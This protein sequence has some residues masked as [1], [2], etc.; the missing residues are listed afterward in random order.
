MRK[1]ILGARTR[2]ELAGIAPYTARHSVSTQLVV[3]RVHP[4]VK[5]QILGH[6]VTDMSRH[7]TN[8][9]QAPL[10]EAIN[11]LPVVPAWAAAPW[12]ADPLAFARKVAGTP[13]KRN[14]M[15]VIRA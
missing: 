7:Y 14:D 4:H 5:D 12:M 13:G 8:V 9:P 3:N 2:S 6:A 15:V 10:I 11:T 1:A